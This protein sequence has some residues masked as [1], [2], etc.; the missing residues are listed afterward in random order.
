MSPIAGSTDPLSPDIAVVGKA[1]VDKSDGVAGVAPQSCLRDDRLRPTVKSA[2][3][4]ADI[5]RQVSAAQELT[6]LLCC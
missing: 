5:D 2:E 6:G 3:R 1:C 4:T